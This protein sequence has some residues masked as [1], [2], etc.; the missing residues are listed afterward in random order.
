M[1]STINLTAYFKRIGYKGEQT[2]TLDVLRKLQRL[3]TQA[4][5]FEN[6]NPFLGLPVNLDMESLEQKLVHDGRGGYCFE[7]NLLFK[8]VLE[9]LGFSVKG[10][11]ARVLW[12][13]PKDRITRR[14]HML[15]L[16]DYNGK[17]HIADVGFGASTLTGPMQLEPNLIQKTPHEQYRLLKHE[18]GYYLLEVQIQN[19]WKTL[20]RFDLQEQFLPDYEMASWY[21][22]NNPESH[23]VTDLMVARPDVDCRYTLHNNIFH[24]HHL[25]A[26]TKRKVLKTPEELRNILE[27]K[28]QL[29]L[30][31]ISEVEKALDQLTKS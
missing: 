5:P 13:Q 2:A 31:G 20:Y 8:H 23:F 26:E 6:L 30:P 27:N 10:L 14:S 11:A 24:V 4:I 16:I 1:E 29:T 22:S 18:K 15:L 19:E 28:F 12:N 3:H 21:L 25:K 17:N 9:K 7:Q